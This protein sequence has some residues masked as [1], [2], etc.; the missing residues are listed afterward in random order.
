MDLK[1]NEK[2]INIDYYSERD[3]KEYTKFLLNTPESNIY[4][5][6]EWKE[7]IESYYNFKPYYLISRDN[8]DNIRAI[9]PSF[10][11]KNMFGK[12]TDKHAGRK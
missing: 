11:I 5:T 2:K 10:Y 3:K 6:T 9:M 12:R 8:N 1:V 7:V 4:H